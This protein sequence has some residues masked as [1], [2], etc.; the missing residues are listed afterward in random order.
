VQPYIPISFG[1]LAIVAAVIGGRSLRQRLLDR[2]QA[3]PRTALAARSPIKARLAELQ[4][5]E[6][7]S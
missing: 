5:T 6:A 4:L 2:L 3:S 1:V 7:S